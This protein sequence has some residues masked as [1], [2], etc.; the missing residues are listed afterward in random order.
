MLHYLKGS[1]KMGT[2]KQILLIPISF[3]DLTPSKNDVNYMLVWLIAAFIYVVMQEYLIRG[4][5]FQI[6]KSNYRGG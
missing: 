3:T 5:V 2:A 1:D 4:Y 6:F